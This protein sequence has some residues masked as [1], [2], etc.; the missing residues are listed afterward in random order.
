M[1][2]VVFDVADYRHSLTS[3]T[4][5]MVAAGRGLSNIVETLLSLGASL[6]LVASN[7]WTA[8]DW[9]RRFDQAEVIELIEA[10]MYV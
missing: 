5:L 6:N 10:H 3:V 4:A 1:L 2:T 8:L 9:A 7:G